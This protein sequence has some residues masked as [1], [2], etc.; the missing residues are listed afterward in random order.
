MTEHHNHQPFI[1]MKL[2][3]EDPQHYDDAPREGKY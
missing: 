2:L 1:V 3:S